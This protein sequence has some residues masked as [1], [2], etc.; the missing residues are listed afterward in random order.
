M[1]D[2]LIPISIEG[3]EEILKQMKKSICKIHKKDGTKGTGFF[4]QIKYP[5]QD[6]YIKL[7]ISN[8]HILDNDDISIDKIITIS[9]NNGNEFKFI[10]IDNSRKVFTSEKLDVTFIELKPNIDKIENLP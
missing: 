1:N 8:N 9:I 4:C 7:L 6:N 10:K 2:S 5:N 3:T